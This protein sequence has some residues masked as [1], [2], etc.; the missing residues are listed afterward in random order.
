MLPLGW[1]IWQVRAV[2]AAGLYPN[3]ATVE[4]RAG[5]LTPAATHAASASAYGSSHVIHTRL[6]G[7]VA[8]HPSSINFGAGRFSHPFLLDHEKVL[9]SK[10]YLRETTLVGGYALLLFAGSVVVNHDH[11]TICV[12]GWISFN[13][14]VRAAVL[15]KVR[16]ALSLALSLSLSLSLSQQSVERVWTSRRAC[17]DAI[18]STVRRS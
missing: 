2:V 17:A 12:D 6:D 4:S 5:F 13:A 18:Q 9:S 16:L 14:P 3:I 1:V 10:I 8:V 11:G 15:F 7:D